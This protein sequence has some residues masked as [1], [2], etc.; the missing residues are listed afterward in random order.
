M[1]L[2]AQVSI[3]GSKEAIWKVITDIENSAQLIT[4]IEQIDILERPDSGIVGLKW[5]ETRTMFGRAATEVMWITNAED[6]EFYE[7]RAESHGAIY[8]SRLQIEEQ[9]G[10]SIL[11]MTF[12]GEPQQLVA[13]IMAFVTGFIFRRATQNALQADLEDI[14]KVVEGSN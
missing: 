5:R 7:T 1:Q 8:R 12:S 11:T 2:E 3:A 14:K 9:G 13:K 10:K 4:A 6:N